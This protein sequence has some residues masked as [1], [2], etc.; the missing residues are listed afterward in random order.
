MKE[1]TDAKIDAMIGFVI[2]ILA[3]A[4]LVVSVTMLVKEK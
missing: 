3:W 2:L 1:V 4:A